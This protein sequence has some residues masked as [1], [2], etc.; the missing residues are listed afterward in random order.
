MNMS[1]TDK[2]RY[3]KPEKE[4]LKQKLTDLQYRVT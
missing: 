3:M 2:G 1:Q 4:E